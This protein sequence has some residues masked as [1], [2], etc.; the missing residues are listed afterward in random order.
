MWVT[1]ATQYSL[2]KKKLNTRSRTEA[3]FSG[4]D[5]MASNI[6]WDFFLLKIKDTILRRIFCIK[7]TRVIFFWRKWAQERW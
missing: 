3:E 6:L 7:I 4:N 2:M 1:V 5:D